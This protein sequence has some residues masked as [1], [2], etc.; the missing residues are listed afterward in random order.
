MTFSIKDLLDD[1][2]SRARIGKEVMIARSVETAN[3]FLASLLPN[4]YTDDARAVSLKDGVL[5]I[6]CKN[7]SA[8]HFVSTKKMD[9]LAAVKRKVPESVI[10]RIHTRFVDEYRTR[11]VIE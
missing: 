8:N 5:T 2:V 9:L 10:M 1:A 7:S 11:N 3:A 6:D 4:G